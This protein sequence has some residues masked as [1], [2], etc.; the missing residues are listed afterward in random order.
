MDFLK[1]FASFSF[2]LFF[3][4]EIEK[5]AVKLRRNLFCDYG[6]GFKFERNRKKI[7]SQVK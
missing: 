5:K 7:T 1:T 4:R 3:R 2:L 6:E